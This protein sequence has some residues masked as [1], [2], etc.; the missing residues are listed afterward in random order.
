MSG[1]RSVAKLAV[2]GVVL[3]LVVGYLLVWRPRSNELSSVRQD[4]DTMTSQLVAV[5]ASTAAQSQSAGAGPSQESK[6][7]AAAV[8]ATPELANLLRQLQ[9]AGAEVGVGPVKV[10]PAPAAANSTGAGSSVAVV[11]STSGTR[12][13]LYDYLHRL[14]SLE[15]L[16]AVD[17]M[18]LEPATSGGDTSASSVPADSYQLDVTGRAF[19][20][21]ATAA[22]HG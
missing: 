9:A 14:S 1:P 22:S 5:R 2:V 8:P 18:T 17:K 16:F 12:S 15:R 11:I 20:S 21:A 6:D 4:R 7:L 3:V 13:V 19:T 10:S